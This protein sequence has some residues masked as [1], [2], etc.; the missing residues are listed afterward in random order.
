[1]QKKILNIIGAGR[2]GKTLGR[3]WHEA[4]V[5]NVC[6]ILNNSL[7]SASEAADFIGAGRAVTSMKD[8]PPADIFQITMPDDDIENITHALLQSEILR[9]GNIVFH[10]SG[11]LPS[12][13]FGVLQEKNVFVASIHP[14]KSFADSMQTIESFSGTWCGV[15]GDKSA[16]E[17][18]R[19]AF[20]K[21]GAKL[22]SINIENKTL[23]HTGSVFACN[24]IPALIEAGLSCFEKA[25]I[26]R[27]QASEILKPIIEETVENIFKSSPKDALTGPISRGDMKVVKR[28]QEA[29]DQWDRDYAELYKILGKRTVALADNG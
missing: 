26:N 29:L 13:V 10:C 22:F 7:N 9:E 15:E 14:V 24:Y 16:L 5:F 28:Q 25:G 20:E 3:L 2:V 4:G 12:A 11:A 23:Y 19:P 21:L 8:L 6:G 1:M 18:L 27:N 17:I